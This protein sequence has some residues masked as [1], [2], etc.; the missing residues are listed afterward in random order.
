M[1]NGEGSEKGLPIQGPVSELTPDEDG[2]NRKISTIS[3]KICISWQYLTH[4]QRG[5]SPASELCV[6][7]CH[8][9]VCNISSF[10]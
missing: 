10:L 8:R 3:T 7:A 9:T 6:V 2:R 5:I 1:E 4:L